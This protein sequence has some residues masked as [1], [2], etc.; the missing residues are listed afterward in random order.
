MATECIVLSQ[1]VAVFM[2]PMWSKGIRHDGVH[3]TH[4]HDAS[5]HR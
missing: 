5:A 3:E 2:E 4:A 1:A